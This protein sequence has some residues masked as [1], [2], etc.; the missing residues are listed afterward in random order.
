[1]EYA[2]IAFVI[3]F[4]ILIHEAGHLMAAKLVG[5]PI[6]RF[7]IGFGPTLARRKWGSTE[8][9]L[10]A[11]PLGGYVMP[12]VKEAHEFY[13]IGGRRR[14]LFSLGG[15]A[16]NLL[17]AL[18]ALSALNIS[19]H[20]LSLASLL[21]KP[22]N[23]LGTLFSQ[24]AAALPMLL[25]GPQNLSGIVG[26]VAQGG[27]YSG[28]DIVRILEFGVFINI[29]LAFFNLLPLPPLDGG[30]I[31]L[32]LL[33]KLHPRVVEFHTLFSAAGWILLAGLTLY[34]TGLDIVRLFPGG[35]A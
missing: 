9:V 24:V 11:I 23:Q 3:G 34:V 25:S 16:F 22:A 14:I 5:I 29:N 21:L 1:M 28:L 15:P 20:G 10:S 31:L 2:L 13:L 18:L 26:V 12:A 32:T 8:F 17:S 7:S 33:E 30:K 27:R 6:E 35:P 19:A 4:T